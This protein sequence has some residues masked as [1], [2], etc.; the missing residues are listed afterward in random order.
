MS[1]EKVVGRV[2]TQTQ[3]IDEENLADEKVSKTIGSF[4]C[5]SKNG[6][7]IVLS[8]NL[9]VSGIK[10]LQALFKFTA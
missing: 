2:E 6:E 8:G 1:E 4:I 9:K 3:K 10:K 7:T 5:R